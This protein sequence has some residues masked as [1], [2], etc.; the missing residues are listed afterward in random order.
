VVVA[1]KAP[2]SVT[3]A[4]DPPAVGLSV[5][6]IVNVC[7]VVALLTV[8]VAAALVALFPAPSLAIAVSTCEPLLVFVVSHEYE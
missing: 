1:P 6:D 4:P 5:P 8:T 7:G 2:L 3:V